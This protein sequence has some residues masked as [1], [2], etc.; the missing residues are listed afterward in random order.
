MK[1]ALFT[2]TFLPQINGVVRTLEKIILHLE[3]NGHKVLVFTIGE[4]ESQYSKT[5]IVRLDG[6]R[7]NLYKELYIV[8]PEDKWVSKFVE[9]D[10][11]QAPMAIL[12]SLIPTRHSVV[13]E[14]LV[15]FN[16]D[17]IHLAT[18]VTLGAIGLYYVDKLKLPSLATYHTDLAAY[19][20]MYHVPYFEEVINGVTKMIYSK[21]IRVLAPSPSSKKQLE[22]LGLE[23]VGVLGRGVDQELF[24]P[25]KRN[26]EILANYDLDPNKITITYVGRLAEEKSIPELVGI[27]SSLCEKYPIQLLVIG[28]GPIKQE[29]EDSLDRTDGTYAFTGIRKGTELVELYAASDIFAFP[30]KTE[31]FGQVVLEAM[32]SGLPIVAYESPGVRDLIQDKKNGYLATSLKDFELCLE[33]LIK[34]ANLRQNYA[35]KSRELSMERS[36]KNILD[37]LLTEYSKLINQ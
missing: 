25:N 22:E 6:I 9:N 5:K 37:G 30:S 11:M 18:P 1:V 17:I 16:P 27:F 20:P 8:K 13:E 34:D 35:K 21:V 23:N 14:A 4:G 26:R 19:A 15:Q 24:S 7:F 33:S 28:D 3:A 12:Q 10:L 36:W 32:A 29:L 2:E 31:T